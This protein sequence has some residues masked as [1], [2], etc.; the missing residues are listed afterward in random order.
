VIT[1]DALTDARSEAFTL[2]SDNEVGDGIAKGKVRFSIVCSGGG[3]AARWTGSAL[4]S[5]IVLDA[6]VIEGLKQQTVYLRADSKIYTHSWQVS[7]DFKVML[8]DK[9]ATRNSSKARKPEF[10]S[11]K[12]IRTL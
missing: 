11:R 9:R 3:K 8:V 2:E 1:R 12:Q 4:G 6:S 7:S 5:P 10:S